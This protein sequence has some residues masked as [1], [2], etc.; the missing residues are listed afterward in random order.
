MAIGLDLLIVAGTGA[1]KLVAQFANPALV[2][3][4]LWPQR[5]AFL[6]ATTVLSMT[7]VA[8]SLAPAYRH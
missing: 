8:A 7:V 5:L 3:A 1:Y 4:L 6:A 2:V